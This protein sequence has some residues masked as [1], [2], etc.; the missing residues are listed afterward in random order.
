MKVATKE[1]SK[2]MIG[3]DAAADP[4]MPGFG[5]GFL[6]V[7]NG[8]RSDYFQTAYSGAS[9]IT[10]SRQRM[11]IPYISRSGKYSV[12]Y[13]SYIHN[14]T[15]KSLKEQADKVG[16]QIEWVAEFVS[17]MSVEFS[18]NAKDKPHQVLRPLLKTVI[19][20]EQEVLKSG[21]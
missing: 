18:N 12:F 14:E 8:A 1:A 11:L 19:P 3:S 13:N 21:D 5:R 9:A 6:Y 17:N 4:L 15:A 20:F 16:T 10:N 7:G 2:E